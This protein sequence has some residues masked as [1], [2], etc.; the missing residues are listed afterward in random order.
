MCI[1]QGYKGRCVE[2]SGY[3]PFFC[4]VSEKG[5][6]GFVY[7]NQS[8]LSQG[9]MIVPLVLGSL[10]FLY[11]GIETL[12][13][14]EN[15][16]KLQ[17]AFINL[18]PKTEESQYTY[19]KRITPLALTALGIGLSIG[20]VPFLP[21]GLSNGMTAIA[22]TSCLSLYMEGSEG[23]KKITSCD[24]DIK[25]L[26]QKWFL[27]QNDSQ[28]ELCRAIRNVARVLVG[29]SVLGVSAWWMSD[30]SQ[31]I[32]N[33]STYEMALPGQSAG[34][35]FLE[36]FLFAAAHLDQSFTYLM[37]SVQKGKSPLLN[38][39]AWFHACS[40]GVTTA[41][42]FLYMKGDL[43]IHHTLLGSGFM[44]LPFMS[45]KFLGLALLADGLNYR[46]NDSGYSSYFCNTKGDHF[47][48][49]FYSFG[50]DN[51]AVNNF[52]SLFSYIAIGCCL[53]RVATGAQKVIQ[54]LVKPKSVLEEPLCDNL[55]ETA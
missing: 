37:S 16:N 22:A 55:Y 53:E 17:K 33:S 27:P 5:P 32:E 40:A 31:I 34:F 52:A 23:I 11:A 24:T 13:S 30:L 41:L 12:R 48:E 39:Y 9:M 54:D 45:L 2:T 50:I 46:F 47:N 44:L 25:K 38:G 4:E 26:C 8:K 29:L 14:E 6:A 28:L 51:V 3:Y 49:V 35:V 15:Q 1:P 18:V 19:L 42:P 7:Q 36:Y 10:C 43:R 21:E 20:I